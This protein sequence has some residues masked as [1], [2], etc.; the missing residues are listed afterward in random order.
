M[1]TTPEQSEVISR[2]LG[3]SSELG[4][5]QD[6]WKVGIEK[7]FGAIATGQSEDSSAEVEL[8][9]LQAKKLLPIA[10]ESQP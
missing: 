5:T 1:S 9:S 6:P 8:T 7:A 10:K 3:P 2:E 4:S